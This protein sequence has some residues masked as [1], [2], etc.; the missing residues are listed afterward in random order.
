MKKQS[1][2]EIVHKTMQNYYNPNVYNYPYSQR[3]NNKRGLNIVSIGDL[4][5]A[6]GRDKEG[7][8]ITTGTEWPYFYLSVWQRMEMVRLSSP[9]FGIITSRMNRVSA[10][11]FNIVPKKSIEDRLPQ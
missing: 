7:N 6:T 10:I 9:I 2:E 8:L 3:D 1:V 4:I 11:D 5:S